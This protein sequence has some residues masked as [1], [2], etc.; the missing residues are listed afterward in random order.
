MQFLFQFKKTTLIYFR[1][2]NNSDFTKYDKIIKEVANKY[3]E[4]MYFF[5]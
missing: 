2:Q 3:N 1:N 5:I 4:R